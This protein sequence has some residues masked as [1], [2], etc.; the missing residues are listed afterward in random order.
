MGFEKFFGNFWQFFENIHTSFFLPPFPFFFVQ[1]N[2]LILYQVKS[3]SFWFDC[4]PGRCQ[5]RGPV[6]IRTVLSES[7]TEKTDL[8]FWEEDFP[9]RYTVTQ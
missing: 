5:R 9:T 1:K 8:L 7:L 3:F 4:T 2:V 6:G